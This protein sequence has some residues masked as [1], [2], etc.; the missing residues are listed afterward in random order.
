GLRGYVENLNTLSPREFSNIQKRY[1]DLELAALLSSKVG[2]AR[3]LIEG[4]RKDGAARYTPRTLRQAEL[5]LHNAE[6]LIAAQR[7]EPENYREAVSK[8]QATAQWLVAVLAATKGPKGR[9]DEM[10]ARNLVR[11]SRKITSLE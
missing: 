2:P 9:L 7:H 4:A 5:E 10:T 6:N 8:A 3:A 11:Q 1:L